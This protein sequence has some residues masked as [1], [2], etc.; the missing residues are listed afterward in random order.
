MALN[1]ANASSREG[2][3]VAIK[4]CV[5][6]NG[7]NRGQRELNM[8]KRLASVQTSS[9][10]VMRIIDHFELDGPNGTH[11]CL[12]LELLGPSV[13]D[14]VEARFSDGRLPGNIAK[15]VAKQALLG[16][17][18]LHK[19]QI[20]HGDMHVRNLAFAMSSTNH[21]P[22]L[23][24]VKMLGEPEIGHV[25][26]DD[27]KCL[28]PGIP[29][30]IVRPAIPQ[31]W[32]LSNTIKIVDFGESFTQNDAPETLHTPLV[33]RAP[34]VI[35]KDRLDHRVDLWSLGCTLFE[36]FVGQPP[37]DNFMITPKILVEQMQEMAGEALPDRW[38][39]LWKSMRG[40]D[41][42][43]YGGPGLQEWLEEMYFDG[44]RKEDLSKDDIV[45]LGR[46]IRKLLRF[47]PGARA[48]VEE[49]LDEPW[50]RD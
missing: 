21:I 16:L 29:D 6:E 23:D 47:E 4:I 30:Y 40:E 45:E 48:S 9:Q 43:E 42:T 1:I 38:V 17:S 15:S 13:S 12:V 28:E 49:I 34:E 39:P 33:V 26:R 14:F 41:V 46:I 37:F 10:H 7:D 11:R 25:R 50:F 2:A 20:A 27:G 19:Q 5:S 22:E 32:P 36:L 35:F 18:L 31:T 3:Y 24:F 44:E 8:L